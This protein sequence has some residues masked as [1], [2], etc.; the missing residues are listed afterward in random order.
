M[1]IIN[2]DI[3]QISPPTA[4]K[5]CKK[6]GR[7]TEY[8]CSGLFRVNAHR[9]N[10][11][12]WLI[13]KCSECDCTWNMTIYSRINPKSIA[14]ETLEGFHQNDEEL[15]KK[16]AMDVNLIKKNGA[17]VGRFKYRK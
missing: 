6:C 7:K 1:K 9:K 3:H 4:I 12:I 11:D 8:V 5:H 2:L 16:Y 17:D 14:P 15:V 13:Y 10:L